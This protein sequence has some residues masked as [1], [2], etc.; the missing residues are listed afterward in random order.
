MALL[1]KCKIT[2]NGIVKGSRDLL[3]KYWVTLH[4]IIEATNIKL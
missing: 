4:E 1:K 3:S 2:S